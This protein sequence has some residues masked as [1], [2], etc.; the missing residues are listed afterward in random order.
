M[1]AIRSIYDVV[2]WVQPARVPPLS[3]RDPAVGYVVATVVIEK[4][5]LSGIVRMQI[6]SFITN[7]IVWL[8]SM[9]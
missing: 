2:G 6:A 9:L 3:F 8:Y 4:C 7:S 5:E 1:R